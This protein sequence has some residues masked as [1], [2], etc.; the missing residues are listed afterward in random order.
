M[1]RQI[2]ICGKAPFCCHPSCHPIL[3]DGT[4]QDDSG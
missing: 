1:M 2:T 3:E 4:L